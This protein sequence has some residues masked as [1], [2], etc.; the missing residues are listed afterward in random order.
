MAND[1]LFE[2]L[3]RCAAIN[4]AILLLWFAVFVFAHDWT[5][6]MHSRWFRLTPEAFDAMNFV[7]IA[8]YKVGII[9]FFIVPAIALAWMRAG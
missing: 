2:F 5:Y 4:Y 7:A 9:L 1:K 3:L 8:I 6:R